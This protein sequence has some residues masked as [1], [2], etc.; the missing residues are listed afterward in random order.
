MRNRRVHGEHDGRDLGRRPQAKVDALDVPVLSPLLEQLD[1]PPA[2]ADGRLSDIVAHALR[3]AVRIE[4]Q[5]QVDVGRVIEFAAAELSHRDHREAIRRGL[6]RALRDCSAHRSVDCLVG[7]VRQRPSHV[8]QRPFTREVAERRNERQ[9]QA[10]AP[11]LGFDRVSR[12]GKGDSRSRSRALLGEDVAEI[13]PG[14]QRVTQ[15]RR[16]ALCPL[17]CVRPGPGWW[18]GRHLTGPLAQIVRSGNFPC[19]WVVSPRNEGTT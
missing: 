6:G 10:L 7:E 3:Q 1:H 14:R 9:S 15:E 13:P 12:H 5:Q 17:D 18:L 19:R 16:M 2:D 4:Q 11:N 8:L